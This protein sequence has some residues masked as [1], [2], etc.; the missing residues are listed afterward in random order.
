MLIC[1]P[2]ATLSAEGAANSQRVLSAIVLKVCG[3]GMAGFFVGRVFCGATTRGLTLRKKASGFSLKFSGRLKPVTHYPVSTQKWKQPRLACKGQWLYRGKYK[4]LVLVI[5][6]INLPRQR[7]QKCLLLFLNDITRNIIPSN[8]AEIL[9]VYYGYR[10]HPQAHGYTIV[11]F[12]PRVFQ[13]YRIYLI[14][15]EYHSRKNLTNNLY[16]TCNN[17][18]L[19]RG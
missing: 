16:V 6:I 1:G 11:V 12:H 9:L 5:S 18:S 7:H 19:S 14:P 4:I 3:A 10:V 15:W 2:M 8:G 13:G 17:H